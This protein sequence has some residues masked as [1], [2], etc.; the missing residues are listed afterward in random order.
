[1]VM[2]IGCTAPAPSPC[3]ARKAMSAGIDHANPQSTEPIRK[4]PIPSS[5]SGFRPT[6]SASLA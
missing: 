2:A 5:I 4:S 1:M 3:T 6:M